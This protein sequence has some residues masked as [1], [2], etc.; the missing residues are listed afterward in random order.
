MAHRVRF[1]EQ[2]ELKLSYNAAVDSQSSV[3]K[4]NYVEST[5]RI[6]QKT[7]RMMV[8]TNFSTL[9]L[10]P[11]ELASYML[12]FENKVIFL[13]QKDSCVFYDIIKGEK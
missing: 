13:K 1:P 9:S 3:N 7:N 2:F 11:L 5:I 12:D 8:D 4:T 6:D 10:A